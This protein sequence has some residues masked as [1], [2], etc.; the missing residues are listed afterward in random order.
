LQGGFGS[1][2]RID[3]KKSFTFELICLY[4]N[5]ERVRESQQG[6]NRLLAANNRLLVTDVTPPESVSTRRQNV[7]VAA[8]SVFHLQNVENDVQNVEND[9][10]NDAK[11][12][13]TKESVL[14]ETFLHE[15]V[16]KLLPTIDALLFAVDA[17]L[18]DVEDGG[19]QVKV[20]C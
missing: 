9:V 6:L 17:T 15:N 2:V 4:T 10:Q 19:D 1:G 7:N 20:I 8:E 3:F 11:D 5:S 18:E 12:D 16:H 13:V 14:P